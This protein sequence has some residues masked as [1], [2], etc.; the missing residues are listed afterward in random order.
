MSVCLSGLRTLANVLIADLNVL[1]ILLTDRNI[2]FR[3]KNLNM[4]LLNKRRDLTLNAIYANK[5]MKGMKFSSVID[6]KFMHV[7]LDAILG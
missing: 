5:P 6:A 3:K 4:K 1:T 2:R 7:I